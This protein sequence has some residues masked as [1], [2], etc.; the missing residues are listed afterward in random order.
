MEMIDRDGNVVQIPD[1]Q[2][3][4]AFRSG[5]Y[6]FQKGTRVP[7]VDE[8]GTVGT[9][10]A[11]EAP[12]AFAIPELDTVSAETFRSAEQERKY[13]GIGGQAAAF[14]I[15]AADALTLG[16]G[17]GLAVEGAEL[18]GG[19][20]AGAATREAIRGYTETNP[21]SEMA[22]QV[23]G[24]AAPI[25]AGGIGGIAGKG[26]RGAGAGVRALDTAGM[27]V[28]RGVARLLPE[29][30]SLA[31]RAVSRAVT[32]G[33]RGATEG[34]VYGAGGAYSESVLKNEDLTAERV[35][36][37]MG[38]GAKFGAVGGAA[39][40]ASIE[41]ASTAIR[42]ASSAALSRLT[43]AADK[44]SDAARALEAKAGALE[45]KA[46]AAG[47]TAGAKVA[48]T[49]E[50]AVPAP[51]GAKAL[52]TEAPPAAAKVVAATDEVAGAARFAPEALSEGQAFP[53]RT[54]P[55]PAG[56]IKA[57]ADVEPIAPKTTR[58]GAAAAPAE[59]VGGARYAPEALNEDK[60]FP[61]RTRYSRGAR[62][63][64][65]PQYADTDLPLG[66]VQKGDI[67]IEEL[68]RALVAEGYNSSNRAEKVGKLMQMV[69]E[70]SHPDWVMGMTP[71][72]RASMWR[73]VNPDADDFIVSAR[74]IKD[75]SDV[76][77]LLKDIPSDVTWRALADAVA[78]REGIKG[79]SSPKP[80]A[81]AAPVIDLP[82]GLKAPEKAAAAAA[83]PASAAAEKAAIAG[84]GTPE[85][86]VFR[87]IVGRVVDWATARAARAV[88]SAVGGVTGGPLGFL[89]GGAAGAA[90]DR[91][92]GKH[93]ETVNGRITDA[94]AGFLGKGT[95]VPLAPTD[96][97]GKTAGAVAKVFGGGGPSVEPRAKGLDARYEQA[98]AAVTHL[99][100][101]PVAHSELTKQTSAPLAK[102]APGVAVKIAIKQ[103]EA[104]KFLQSKLPPSVAKAPLSS[105]QVRTVGDME[106]ASFL[107]SLRTVQHPLSVVE[108]LKDGKM[109]SK[110]AV[111]ALQAVY[112]EMYADLRTKVLDQVTALMAEGKGPTYQQ[113]LQIGALFDAAV[114]PTQRPEIV[115]AVQALYAEMGNVTAPDQGGGGTGG[116]KVDTAKAHETMTQRLEGREG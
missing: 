83:A 64:I 68:R 7:V 77:P 45:A 109:P 34:S 95:P 8:L 91:V 56:G 43:Q 90:V 107:R 50:E 4:Q 114:D 32:L 15:G 51:P 80:G 96:V 97:A 59:V 16:A 47:E 88:G 49:A 61:R 66:G 48:R 100:T 86:E 41:V 9:I 25:L 73:F 70:G 11:A 39:L 67:E 13:G 20:R 102:H 108:D 65:E 5:Q 1:E 85:H 37:G 38:E 53:R 113:R 46:A 19:E 58:V 18:I 111:E 79:W 31:G 87:D 22:G 93:M 82:V 92:L 12:E 98:A 60:A 29:A 6:G 105:A 110:D 54:A 21:K 57:L 99:A 115:A 33:A 26:I 44:A 14:G 40:G 106:K 74:A 72:Q 71:E 27:A 2:A 42:K 35:M 17:K 36:A 10:D 23:I 104:I 76:D 75:A 30:E 89:A 55:A 101:N 24:T 52:A 3:G 63:V 112:P 69:P 62:D 94:V 28:E 103:G 81:P 116:A 78:E 84:A